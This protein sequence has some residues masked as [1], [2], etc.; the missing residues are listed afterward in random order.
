MSRE[1]RSDLI[2]KSLSK[3]VG[4]HSAVPQILKLLNMSHPADIARTLD[5][6]TETD[7]WF[8]WG[9]M[10]NDELKAETLVE[11]DPETAHTMLEKIKDISI[12][13]MAQKLELDDA[14][15]LT[16]LLEES[17]SKKIDLL[18]QKK[19]PKRKI[20]FEAEDETA[21]RLMTDIYLCIDQNKTV[22]DALAL[23]RNKENV[24]NA[25]YIY[26][27]DTKRKLQGVISL[28][29]LLLQEKLDAPLKTVMNTQVFSVPIDCDQQEVAHLI[30]KY[31]LVS[32]PVVND[33]EELVGII[34]V[35]DALDI[36]AEEA[37]E[38]MLKFSGVITDPEEK[39]EPS[40]AI[41][42]KQRL[43]WLVAG[44][45]GGI[46]AMSALT[47]FESQISK[48]WFL[49]IFIPVINGMSGNVG[50]Q[51]SVMMIQG[52][53]TNRIDHSRLVPFFFRE[54]ATGAL[55]GLM[56]GSF[57]AFIT[58][59]FIQEPKAVPLMVGISLAISMFTAT[60]I[61]VFVPFIFHK[62]KIDPSLGA[63]P[64]VPTLIDI[65]AVFLFFLISSWFLASIP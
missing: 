14:A 17:R 60:A 33:Q 63:S 46:L 47:M 36:I 53:A 52:L 24:E 29:I 58:V 37:H 21:A 49:T 11:C 4:H 41:N 19:D 18:L 45:M 1:E 57:L 44:C 35:D 40:I 13:R 65:T 12:L 28:K 16:H 42:I 26:V 32:L 5:I 64:L 2:V 39:R 62:L 9:L 8:L 10:T 55:L 20:V 43:P 38:D 50:I 54:L 48:W 34:T 56:F 51:A 15:Q 30:E 31:N 7:R 3:M 22:Q 59:L 61:G 25:F 27:I 6:S 23:V